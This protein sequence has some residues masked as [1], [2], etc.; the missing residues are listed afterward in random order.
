MYLYNQKENEAE[1]RLNN[2]YFSF[3][4]GISKYYAYLMNAKEGRG[5]E[6][7][8]WAYADLHMTSKTY[9]PLV[10]A[11]GL[12]NEGREIFDFYRNKV[13]EWIIN[14]YVPSDDEYDN[15]IN[16]L[17]LIHATFTRWDSDS[18]LI[19]WSEEELKKN[20]S[21]LIKQLTLYE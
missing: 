11:L 12:P 1:H 19:D 17:S 4:Y 6:N 5:N 14:D 7:L 8:L 15:L 10:A 20:I 21:D 16:D 9:L 18:T 13:E 3:E 2:L